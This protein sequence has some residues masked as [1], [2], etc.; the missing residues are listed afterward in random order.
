MRIAG[1][2]IELSTGERQQVSSLGEVKKVPRES[3][4]QQTRNYD[5]AKASKIMTQQKRA[6][7]IGGMTGG[8]YG[9][10][11]GQT[12]RVSLDGTNKES[13]IAY[14]SVPMAGSVSD[15]PSPRIQAI[16]FGYRK[17]NLTGK[18]QCNV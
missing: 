11:G 7:K 13:W 12:K 18:Q 3:S 9:R 17:G 2:L 10:A 5:P 8:R 4:E 1:T 15:M 16:G 14:E 6:S